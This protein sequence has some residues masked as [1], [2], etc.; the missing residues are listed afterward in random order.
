MPTPG[1]LAS[2]RR[3]GDLLPV[4]TLIEDRSRELGL[5]RSELV[6]RCGYKNMAKGI[7]GS[8]NSMRETCRKR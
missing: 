2:V 3:Q 1:P 4:Q 5:S 6:R 8:T 7:R